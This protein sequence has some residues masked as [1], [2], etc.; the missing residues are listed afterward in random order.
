MRGLGLAGVVWA[1]GWGL[2]SF[3]APGGGAAAGG[4]GGVEEGQLEGALGEVRACRSETWMAS[5]GGGAMVLRLVIDT[6][7]DEAGRKVREVREFVADGTLETTSWTWS[8]EGEEVVE[9]LWDAQ[10]ADGFADRWSRRTY[11]DGRVTRERS[12][13]AGAEDEL[14]VVHEY[15]AAGRLVGVGAWEDG[16]LAGR[17]SYERDAEGRVVRKVRTGVGGARTTTFEYDPEGRLVSASGQGLSFHGHSVQGLVR[18]YDAQGRLVSVRADRDGDGAADFVLEIAHHG[19]GFETRARY[20]VEDSLGVVTGVWRDAL[21]RVVLERHWNG[22]G[23]IWAEVH[24][25]HECAR[26]F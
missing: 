22:F 4:G 10:P 2:L 24:H 17:T 20:E 7:F 12:G 5:E 18:G 9:Q 13:R 21:G 14:V 6:A 26:S 8:G 16:E 11:V 1:A 23:E 3:A 15:D 19:A 25:D